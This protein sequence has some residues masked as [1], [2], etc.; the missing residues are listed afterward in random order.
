MK[1]PRGRAVYL[2]GSFGYNQNSGRKL[3]ILQ[4]A[5]RKAWKKLVSAGLLTAGKSVFLGV[6]R[7]TLMERL[8]VARH[9]ILGT[10][11]AILCVSNDE[12]KEDI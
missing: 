8:Q 2:P 12:I 5:I 1:L 7:Q 3:K 6:I 10:M 11:N 9:V 4:G